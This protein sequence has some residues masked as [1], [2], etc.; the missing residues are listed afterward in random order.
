MKNNILLLLALASVMTASAQSKVNPAG[1]LLIDGF[2]QAQ[3]EQAQ[4]HGSDAVK[5]IP[6]VSMVVILRDGLTSDDVLAASPVE[7]LSEMEGVCVVRCKITDVESIAALEGVQQVGFGEKMTP[8]LDYARPSGGVDAVHKG[9]SHDGKTLKF[10]GTGVVAG[11]MDTGLEANHVNFKNSDGTTR[12]QR[13]WH[14]NSTNGSSIMYTPANMASFTTDNQSESHATHVAGILGGSYKGN[15]QYVWLSSATGTSGQIYNNNPIPFYGVAT[16]AD[17]AFSVGE[18]Y[19]ANVVQGVTNII[20]YAESTGQPCVV[21]MSLGINIGPHDGTDYTAAALS[22]LGRRAIICMSAGNEGDLALSVEK[23]LGATGNNRYLRTFP[24]SQ[25]IKSAIADMW[26]SSN[27][28]IPAGWYLR[29]GANYLPVAVLEGPGVVSTASS[30]TFQQ[31]FNGSIKVTASVSSANNRY[32]V[33]SEI[34]GVSPK[35]GNT[36]A[37]L[38]YSAGGDGFEGEKLLLVGKEVTFSNRATTGGTT[39][40]GF[41][42]GNANNS[43]NNNACAPNIISVGAY[44]SRTRWGILPSSVT[45]FNDSFTL[46]GIAPFS[47]Y[48]PMY[49]GTQLPLVCAPGA[50]LVSSLSNYYVSKTNADATAKA[51]NGAST[52]YWGGMSGTSMASPF[53][54]GV[55]A[56]WLEASP[57]LDCAQVLDVIDNT[58]EFSALTMKGGRW[59]AGKIN[60]LDGVKYI[61]SNASIGGVWDN[62]DQ[63]LL[64]TPTGSGYEVIL[65]GEASFDVKV[66]DL[67][68]RVVAESAGIDGQATVETGNLA[69]GVYIVNV[70]SASYSTSRKIS[71]R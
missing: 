21:N 48:G 66:V 71:V 36:N 22:R 37:V 64:L 14:M 3:R 68:G 67:Q 69:G 35:S 16:G 56:L 42:N 43:I 45:G 63:R 62:D 58:S 23:T 18:L 50:A 57:T 44:T 49:D 52:S 55:V 46:N 27:K 11:M 59:G 34:T 6:Q 17:L 12:I 26:T 60:A 4:L 51:S 54:A 9:F 20:E 38:C 39:V 24:N 25:T 40:V 1:R 31:Y 53:V 28:P 41:S 13:L 61:L 19:N 15:G 65:A 47:S 30:S 10:D 33:Y 8:M 2:R 5:E 70:S 32:N 29:Q 7:L